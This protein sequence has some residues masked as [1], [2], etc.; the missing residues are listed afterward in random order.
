MSKQHPSK[1]KPKAGAGRYD[2]HSPAVDSPPVQRRGRSQGRKE[3][4][5]VAAK[6]SK[7]KSKTSKKRSAASPARR[8]R[9]KSKSRDTAGKRKETG[10][11]QAGKQ[12]W[13]PSTFDEDA[14]FRCPCSGSY[15]YTGF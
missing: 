4:P 12:R 8:G 7:S 9:S 13:S 15:S 5:A 14:S 10:V 6:R 2:A 3:K 11:S 1:S